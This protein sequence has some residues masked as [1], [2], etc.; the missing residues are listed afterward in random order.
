MIAK[1]HTEDITNDSKNAAMDSSQN[2][3]LSL[4]LTRIT[5]AVSLQF[6]QVIPK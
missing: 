6:F 4:L 3:H 5:L 1:L 2:T